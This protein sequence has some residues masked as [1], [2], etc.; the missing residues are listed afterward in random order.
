MLTEREF[1]D[2]DR[3]HH[4]RFQMNLNPERHMRVRVGW[5]IDL[6]DERDKMKAEVERLREALMN[7]RPKGK[8]E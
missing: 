2:A 6:V 8:N 1:F 3:I 7:S 4:A 5:L